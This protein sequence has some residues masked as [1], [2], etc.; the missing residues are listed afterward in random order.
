L[1]ARL[2]PEALKSKFSVDTVINDFFVIHERIPTADDI[3]EMLASVNSL[4][5]K[6]ITDVTL[7]GHVARYA[8]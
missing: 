7:R 2:C 5:W 3:G 6:K 8:Q 4:K 1:F